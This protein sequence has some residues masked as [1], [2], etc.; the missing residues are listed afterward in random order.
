MLL[1]SYVRSLLYTPEHLTARMLWGRN[2]SRPN[3]PSSLTFK[4]A[5][6][7]VIEQFER[8]YLVDSLQAAQGNITHAAESAGLHVT[9]FH[10]K[11]KKYDIHPHS[12]KL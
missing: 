3:S 5:K 6:Q 7:Q 8:D 4:A 9:N 10:A 2:A 1:I 12:F 11:M